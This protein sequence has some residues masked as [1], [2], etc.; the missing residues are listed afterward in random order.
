MNASN[1]QSRPTLEDAFDALKK[2]EA[3]LRTFIERLPALIWCLLPDGSIE[4]FNQQW[5][6]YTGLSRRSLDRGG[7]RLFTPMTSN[8]WKAGGGVSCSL[9]NPPRQTPVSL[10]RRISLIPD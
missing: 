7:S 8:V 9:E 1:G 3:Q 10:R 2:S 4:I 5:R 6:V